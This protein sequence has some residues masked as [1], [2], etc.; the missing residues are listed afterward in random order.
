MPGPRGRGVWSRGWGCLVETTRT[1]TAAAVRILLEC[2][3]V[4]SK[5]LAQVS[6]VAYFQT[7]T[8]TE[9]GEPVLARSKFEKISTSN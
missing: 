5:S 1:I 7:L 3:L 4:C 9:M 6:Y 2:I 8:L